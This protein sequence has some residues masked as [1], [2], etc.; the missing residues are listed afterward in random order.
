MLVIN[1]IF[2]IV[3]TA[4]VVIIVIVCTIVPIVE[5]IIVVDTGI[6]LLASV[7]IILTRR[8]TIV[9]LAPQLLSGFFFPS[10]ACSAFD[11]MDQS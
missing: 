8:V 10:F 7:S 9:D 6:A 4:T 3:V 1:I 5:I 2:V 11:S